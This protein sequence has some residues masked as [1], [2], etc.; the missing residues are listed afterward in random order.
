MAFACLAAYY[1]LYFHGVVTSKQ[2][3]NAV[4]FNR[5]SKQTDKGNMEIMAYGKQVAR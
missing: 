4:A 3:R 1:L 5:E 2:K